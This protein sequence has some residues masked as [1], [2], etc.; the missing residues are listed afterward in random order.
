MLSVRNAYRGFA[1]SFTETRAKFR[2]K[3]DCKHRAPE[4]L[5]GY[6]DIKVWSVDNLQSVLATPVQISVALCLM[7]KPDELA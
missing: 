5:P 7:K 2:I 1:N 6:I 3:G 4:M